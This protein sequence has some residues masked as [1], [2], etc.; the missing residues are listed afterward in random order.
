LT[1]IPSQGKVRIEIIIPLRDND[2]KLIE[3]SKHKQT[4]DEIT[5]RF[6]AG[7]FMI[8]SEGAWTN[9]SENDRIYLDIN[10]SV[11]LLIDNTENNINFFKNYKEILK[12]RY[13]QKV[14]YINIM[15]ASEL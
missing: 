11:W 13:D 12:N 10:A 15:P 9:H 2:G 3:I 14:I 1:S 7:N 8:P 4:K 6:G 5:Q